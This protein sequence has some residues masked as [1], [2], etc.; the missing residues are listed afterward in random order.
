[1]LEMSCPQRGDA[2]KLPEASGL[3]RSRVCTL[4]RMSECGSAISSMMSAAQ[5]A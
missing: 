4:V 3:S 5:V 1:M 2:G